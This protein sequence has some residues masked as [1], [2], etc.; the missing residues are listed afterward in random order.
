MC[1]FFFFQN[2]FAFCFHIGK[3]DFSFATE[4]CLVSHNS[5]D[6]GKTSPKNISEFFICFIKYVY[7]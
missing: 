3:Y 4:Y 5:L 7:M 2:S 6:R 1:Y